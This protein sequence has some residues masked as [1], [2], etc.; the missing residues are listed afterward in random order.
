MITVEEALA[1]YFRAYEEQR[2]EDVVTWF[3]PPGLFVSDAEP[4]SQTPLPT[5][6]DCRA[7][8]QRVLD[9]HRE[10]GA[11][12]SRVARQT[13]IELSPRITCVDVLV[14]VE[15]IDGAKL[16]D[17]E[18]VYTF[19]REGE[20]WRIATAVFNQIPRL[21]ACLKARRAADAARSVAG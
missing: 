9:W 1:E 2:I 14:D 16:Y 10:M 21:L 12:R 5:E 18:S 3:R 20:D 17:F 7:G 4:V 8:V 19:V 13:V 15:D 11:A 6:D